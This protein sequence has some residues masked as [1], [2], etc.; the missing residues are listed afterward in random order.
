MSRKRKW[1]SLN[2]KVEHLRL[3]LEDRNEFISEIESQF[4]QE[5]SKLTDGSIEEPTSQEPD[6][7]PPVVV[8]MSSGL[9]TDEVM[10]SAEKGEPLPE[11]IKKLWKTIASMTH[12][13]KTGN[14][15]IKTELYLS[16][17][18][19]VEEGAVD[20]ITRIALELNIEIPEASEG[21]VV[22]LESL[23]VDLQKK[24]SETENSVLWQWGS[25]SPNIKQ[26]ILE[27]YIRMKKLKKKSQ[28]SV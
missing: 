25:A 11:D 9:E 20:E 24:I 16:A 7:P 5:L 26:G 23:A 13:D 10:S 21:A 28:V 27:A 17:N 15:P 3:E 2:H 19:A 4:L 14:D 18:K 22:K 12:P 8:D 1:K 6:L